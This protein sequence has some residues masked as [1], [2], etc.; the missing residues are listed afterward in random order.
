[1]LKS[2]IIRPSK[3]PWAAPVVLIK[4]KSGEMRFC[5]NYR[6]LNNVTKKDSYPIPR[7]DDTLDKLYGKTGFS[8]LDLVSGYFQIALDEAAKEMSAF[9]VE[10][11]L[12]EFNRMPFGLTNAPSTFQ[13]LMNRD[14]LGKFALVYLDDILIYSETFDEHYEHIETVFQLLTDAGLKLKLKKCHFMKQSVN[15]LGH[16]ISAK[17]ISPDPRKIETIANYKIPVNSEQ[18]ASFLGLV[19]Y[20]RKFISNFGTIARP[21]SSQTKKNK[22]EPLVWGEPEQTAFET[23]RKA[24]ISPPILAFPNFDVSFQ[25]FTD[26]SN[27]GIGAILS[28]IQNGQEVVIAYQSR[29][30][31]PSEVKYTT[32]EKEA[33]A[34]IFAIKRFKHYLIDNEFLVISDHRPLQ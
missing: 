7:I 9:I 20:Y 21:L 2:N 25:I 13:R 5:I 22:K 10:N 26:A 11:N 8:T 14:I 1:M 12:Y 17:G 18:L 28:Q 34:V 6:Q 16:I 24:L 27:Y 15:Y 23:L 33:L 4:K 29:H 3:S 19:G 30:L 31:K 32:I